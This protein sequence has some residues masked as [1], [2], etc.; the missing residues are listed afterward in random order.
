MNGSTKIIFSIIGTLLIMW[1]GWVSI[2]LIQRGEIVV[3]LRTEIAII[4]KQ[5]P[6]IFEKIDCLEEKE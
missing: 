6:V 4:K 2:T 3:E 1:I 5:I